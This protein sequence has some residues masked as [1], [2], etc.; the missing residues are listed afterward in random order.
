[1]R[2]GRERLFLRLFRPLM[3]NLKQFVTLLEKLP[4]RHRDT[5]VIVNFKL[6]PNQQTAIRLLSEQY[7]RTGKIRAIFLKS[8]RVTVSSLVDAILFGDCLA[9]PHRENLIV[10]HVKD[11]S[12]GLFRVPRDLANGLNDKAN[13]CR[14]LTHRI[15]VH[16]RTGLS[17]LDIATAGTVASGRGLTLSGLHLSES[18][19]YPGQASFTSLIPA[20]SKGR[21]TYIFNESTAFGKTGIGQTFHDFWQ[22]AVARKNEYIPIFLGWLQ[23]PACIADEQLASDAPASDLERELMSKPFLATRAQVA[24]M[25]NVLESEC[26]GYDKVF[27]QEYPWTPSVAFQASGDPAF[28]PEEINFSESTC[29]KPALQGHMEWKD[30]KPHFVRVSNGALHIW[31]EPKWNHKYYM[32]MDAAVGMESG[33][34]AAISIWDGTTGREVAQYA[35]RVVP[36]IVSFLLH[37]LGHWYNKALINGELT[38]NSGREV[39]RILRDRYHYPN[40]AMWKGKDDKI[41]GSG[42]NRAPTLWWEMT[43]YSRRKLFDCFRIAIRG[44]IRNEEFKAIVRDPALWSQMADAS[45]SDWGRWEVERGHDDILVSAMLAIVSIA[46]NPVPKM[47]NAHSMPD[48]MLIENEEDNL[49]RLIPNIVDDAVFSL[50][51]HYRKAMEATARGERKK[52]KLIR[53][54]MGVDALAGI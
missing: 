19:Q 34:F 42:H 50:R 39:L 24:W 9:S 37:A 33:D 41:M 8:R 54:Q 2:S 31:E 27:A 23:D 12:E 38:G 35:D 3:L 25:R 7:E 21:G 18:A 5:G 48:H 15:E 16:H 46:Q 26:Q 52:L 6:F 28:T 43:S 22:K 1:M 40:L 51:R 49:K 44:G 14:I 13:V 36:E 10:A 47:S 30:D 4:V 32:G 45:L 17:K 53:R 20:V 29:L 11:T